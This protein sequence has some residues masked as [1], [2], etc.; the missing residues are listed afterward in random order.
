MDVASRYELS[1]WMNM[2][3]SSTPIHT[4]AHELIPVFRLVALG[5]SEEVHYRS[6]Y[7]TFPTELLSHEF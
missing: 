3:L 7:E 6:I 2:A 1:R 5:K 4:H